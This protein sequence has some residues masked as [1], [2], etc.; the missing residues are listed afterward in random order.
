[1]SR[2]DGQPFLDRAALDRPEAECDGQQ[3]EDE[4]GNDPLAPRGRRHQNPPHR[5][6]RWDDERRR[7]TQGSVQTPALQG[8]EA[9]PPMLVRAHAL[10]PSRGGRRSGWGWGWGGRSDCGDGCAAGRV[11][12]ASVVLGD[13]L[14]LDGCVPA[15]R[16]PGYVVLPA[17]PVVCSGRVLVPPSP[18]MLG[19][20]AREVALVA[21]SGL[22]SVA[23]VCA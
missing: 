11:G 21:R 22:R 14:W 3:R 6:A 19:P 1:M 5:E 23:R 17:E 13:P 20:S 4:R 2:N 16:V 9:I 12:G 7:G 18:P 8:A 10:P 15:S